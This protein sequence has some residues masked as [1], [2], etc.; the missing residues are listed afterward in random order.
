MGLVASQNVKSSSSGI[1]PVSSALAGGFLTTGPP[2]KS[3]GLK[4]WSWKTIADDGKWELGHVATGAFILWHLG[5]KDSA[6]KKII[7][8]NIGAFS[9]QDRNSVLAQWDLHP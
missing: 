8:E 4:F 1:K 7:K 5:I 9:T 6:Q 3:S 2:G